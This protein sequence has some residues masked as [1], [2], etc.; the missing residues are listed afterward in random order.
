ME[1]NEQFRRD[2]DRRERREDKSQVPWPEFGCSARAGGKRRQANLIPRVHRLLLP[3]SWRIV[4][5]RVTLPEVR[6][7]DD[8]SGRG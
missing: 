7:A 3:T 8:Y 1:A 5:I 4:I 6:Y 2:G